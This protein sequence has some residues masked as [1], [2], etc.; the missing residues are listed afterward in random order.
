MSKVKSKKIERTL[1]RRKFPLS[2]ISSA[3]NCSVCLVAWDDKEKRPI[4]LPCGHSYC[5]GCVEEN[6]SDGKIV[7]PD[8]RQSYKGSISDF[9][10]NY[11]LE[12]LIRR[13]AN[14]NKAHLNGNESSEES[15][16][17]L[18]KRKA[19][20][21]ARAK[22]LCAESSSLRGQLEM[23]A[24]QLEDWKKG[25]QNYIFFFKNVIERFDKEAQEAAGEENRR[26]R[27]RVPLD[28]GQ[29]HFWRPFLLN[30]LIICIVTFSSQLNKKKKK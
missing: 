23:Y 28:P 10:Y 2:I 8:C 9:P 20:A 4:V 6:I 13:E 11:G 27:V 7:C 17:S 16:E 5:Y 25:H 22:V 12:S 14:K 29:G 1:E 24:M 18:L 26:V 30:V 3:R 19:I 15:M 21:L